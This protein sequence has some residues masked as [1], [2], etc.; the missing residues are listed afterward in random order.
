MLPP[1]L[2]LSISRC[3]RHALVYWD[4]SLYEVDFD[5]SI[6]RRFNNEI[7]VK[8]QTYFLNDIKMQ[9]HNAFEHIMTFGIVFIALTGFARPS[10]LEE[11]FARYVNPRTATDLWLYLYIKIKMCVAGLFFSLTLLILK[12]NTTFE[13]FK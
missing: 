9:L 7:I 13:D 10:E 4:Q 5:F 12:I 8:S 3:L 11:H 6:H 1:L 2:L